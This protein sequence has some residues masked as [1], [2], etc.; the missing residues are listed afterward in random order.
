MGQRAFRGQFQ[1]AGVIGDGLV[2]FADDRPGIGPAHEIH[3]VVGPAEEAIE[4]VDLQGLGFP[5]AEMLAGRL[6]V[7]QIE[8]EP[9]HQVLVVWF[10][11]REILEGGQRRVVD[12]RLMGQSLH[13]VQP[14]G[15]RLVDLPACDPLAGLALH[16]GERFLPG[17]G[18]PLPFDL[19]REFFVRLGLFLDAAEQ[20]GDVLTDLLR[21]IGRQERVVV[22]VRRGHSG[23]A[24]AT[25]PVRCANRGW[26]CRLRPFPLRPA[27]AAQ[28]LGRHRRAIPALGRKGPRASSRPPNTGRPPAFLSTNF[29]GPARNGTARAG[30]AR[31]RCNR[32]P[33]RAAPRADR[34]TDSASPAE[35]RLPPFPNSSSR[36]SAVPGRIRGSK[37]RPGPRRGTPSTFPRSAPAA[38]YSRIRP[39]R[40]W[41]L[42]PR[43][44]RRLPTRCP[45]RTRSAPPPV[46]RPLCRCRPPAAA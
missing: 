3:R 2:V 6:V 7:A 27:P 13:Q 33:A 25:P 5:C 15:G 42:P 32:T 44:L 23:P 11:L 12:L 17:R 1:H 4:E 16:G 38:A 10:R 14:G 34:A 36:H 37:T 30:M 28:S 45:A 29:P 9:T 31:R 24:G 22:K 18:R 40:T 41:I 20:A 26:F 35:K 46:C 19:R 21:V 8:R 39:A 43:E